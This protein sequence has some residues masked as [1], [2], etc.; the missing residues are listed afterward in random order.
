M[1]GLG[2]NGSQQIRKARHALL[3]ERAFVHDLVESTGGGSACSSRRHCS[4]SPL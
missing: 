3:N 4:A 2:I 1:Y